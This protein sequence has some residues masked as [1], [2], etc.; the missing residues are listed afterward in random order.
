VTPADAKTPLPKAGKTLRQLK[1][2]RP[3]EALTI[4]NSSAGQGKT[5]LRTWALARL[6]A[7]AILDQR[8]GKRPPKTQGGGVKKLLGRGLRTKNARHVGHLV[9]AVLLDRQLQRKGARKDDKTLRGMLAL[10]QLSG[11]FGVFVQSRGAKGLL[12]QAKRASSD[13]RCVYRI[14]N[15]MC[16]YEKYLGNA[17]DNFTIESAKEFVRKHFREKN[18]GSS[19]I[20]KIWEKYKTASPH[21]FAI[22]PTWRVL[23]RMKTFHNVVDACERLAT[24]KKRLE[25]LMGR[26]AYAAD[27]MNRKARNVRVSDFT[28]IRRVAPPLL[29]LTNRELDVIA[30]IDRDAP[31]P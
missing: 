10:F 17:D 20:S 26:A 1:R 19:K 13:L 24:D 12:A 21:I 9:L 11:G 4:I 30:T 7:W 22:Y 27:V 23:Q 14:V 8:P 25:K 3:R 6:L 15:Y 5:A 29:C 31:L 2:F 28:A 18:K 16:R